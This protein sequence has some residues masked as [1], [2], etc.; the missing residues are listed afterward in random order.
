MRKEIALLI[1]GTALI[2]FLTRYSFVMLFRN[3]VFSKRVVNWLKY[4]PI[5]ILT[6]LIVPTVLVPKGKLDMTL[7]NDYFIAVIVS[8]LIAYKT[9]N[10][11]ITIIC[12]M[13]VVLAFRF[14]LFHI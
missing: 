1:I 9:K 6:T 8:V 12:G 3:K 11:I 2:T 5:A 14:L 7:N 4:I 13:S 10:V